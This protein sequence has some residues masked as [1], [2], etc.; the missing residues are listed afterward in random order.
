MDGESPTLNLGSDMCITKSLQSYSHTLYIL[1]IWDSLIIFKFHTKGFSRWVRITFYTWQLFLNKVFLLPKLFT[2]QHSSISLL[3]QKVQSLEA[4]SRP[5]QSSKMERFAKIFNGLSLRVLK[6]FS[7]M[8]VWM[9][10][11]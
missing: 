7:F 2:A 6:T 5:C 9:D 4:Y 3:L 11:T 8:D 1:L 10:P